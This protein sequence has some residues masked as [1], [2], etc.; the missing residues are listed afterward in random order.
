MLWYECCHGCDVLGR[1]ERSMFLE[2]LDM[3]VSHS[4]ACMCSA[5]AM[6]RAGVGS[7]LYVRV[8]GGSSWK[9]ISC[10]I[11]ASVLVWKD[12]VLL[13]TMGMISMSAFHS[14]VACTYMACLRGS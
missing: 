6:S 12:P 1:G 7:C 13:M 8:T 2:S 10:A 9:E 5:I 14:P 4:C 3:S 11:A